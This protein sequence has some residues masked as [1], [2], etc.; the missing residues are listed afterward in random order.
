SFGN[1]IKVLAVEKESS[2]RL[3]LLG[4]NFPKWKLERSTS[5]YTLTLSNAQL[6][7]FDLTD[8][9]RNIERSRISDI[10]ATGNNIL[11]IDL[12]CACY[13]SP[14]SSGQDILI[15]DIYEV[16][17][18][19]PSVQSTLSAP[20]APLT[21]NETL[22]LP[23]L[24]DVEPNR[25]QMQVTGTRLSEEV[26]LPQGLQGYFA[27]N[28]ATLL[29]SQPVPSVA[30]NLL[31]RAFARAAAQGLI[32]PSSDIPSF[33][34]SPSSQESAELRERIN[35]TVKTGFDRTIH[36]N[37][38]KIPPTSEGSICFSN[39]QIDIASWGDLAEPNIL[40]R[41]R[42][43]LI[44][45]DG[46]VQPNGAMALAKYYLFLGFG[47]E[48]RK[49]TLF[50]PDGSDRELI[51]ALA[52]IMDTGMTSSS[53]LK[54]QVGCRGAVALW[55][56]LFLPV[57]EM[58]SPTSADDV[59]STFS[60]LP[61]HLRTHLGPSLAKRL[62]A[63]GLPEE[64]RMAIN[65]VTRAGQ[66]TDES[67]LASA[68]LELDGIHSQVARETLAELSTGTSITAAG[69]LLELL[70]DAEERGMPPNPNWVDDAPT[71]VGALEGT[72]IA[73]E[74]N[75]SGLQGLIALG[76][77]DE[78]RA[79][80][81]EPSPGLSVESRRVISIL[82]MKSAAQSANS[83]DFLK[84]EIGLSK[85]VPPD[86]LDR[87]TRLLISRR[88]TDLGLPSRATVYLPANP[89]TS[90]EYTLTAQILKDLGNPEDAITLLESRTT[91]GGA[92]VLGDALMKAGDARAAIAA[93]EDADDVDGAASIAIQIGDWS[94]LAK[95]G[96][97]EI[98][99]IAKALVDPTS[100]SD[101]NTTSPNGLLIANSQDRRSE[102]MNLLELT[103]TKDPQ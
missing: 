85:L 62:Q 92:D 35:V 74:L 78:F 58:M 5:K 7:R 16:D 68:R 57:D 43:D 3:T 18:T 102:I 2:I 80:V 44:A 41:L 69:A 25:R 50:I 39:D 51:R 91:L 65:A 87:E 26:I 32:E 38:R 11:E 81:V 54:G 37:L 8:I 19:K 40:G 66:N 60:A 14:A 52:D 93:Y 100:P 72:D 94:W 63:V 79:K 47:A 42:A 56:V 45:E 48:A 83:S 27:A 73:A 9:F 67:E 36:S 84:T 77:Y 70:K 4:E 28:S 101:Q 89:K 21:E 64:A 61:A 12:V 24:D 33:A 22:F 30:V 59:L 15:I 13:A 99:S 88:L 98:S 76:R 86:A 46:T 23:L 75:I 1:P 6:I 95:N 97:D 82:A 55:A 49:A 29:G 103:S 34:K 17:E 20:I 10:R 90:N 53:I 71:L 96:P 31:S